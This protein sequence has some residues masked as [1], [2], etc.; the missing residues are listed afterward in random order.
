MGYYDP[1]EPRLTHTHRCV[2]PH[3][4]ARVGCGGARCRECETAHCE[5]DHDLDDDMLCEDHRDMPA[6]SYCGERE[7]D[8]LMEHDGDRMHPACVT[9]AGR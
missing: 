7:G 4:T 5:A 8:P 9:E 2:E 3:C 6:C 1:P